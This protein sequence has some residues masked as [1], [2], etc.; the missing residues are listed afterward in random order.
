MSNQV[1][2]KNYTLTVI[3][4]LGVLVVGFASFIFTANKSGFLT[5]QS[6]AQVSNCIPNG[7][8][9]AEDAECC[10]KIADPLTNACEENFKSLG[11]PCKN[12]GGECLNAFGSAYNCSLVGD[13]KGPQNYCID[14]F[15]SNYRCCALP[16]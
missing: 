4:L 14:N 16:E 13:D 8:V 6:Q 12:A 3:F 10:S 7:Q 15:G 11:N 5:S 1:I 9:K 2:R